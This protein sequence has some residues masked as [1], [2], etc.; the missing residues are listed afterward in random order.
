M[1]YTQLCLNWPLFYMYDQHVAF[2]EKK[3]A[4]IAG[5][6]RKRALESHR[7]VEIVYVL[8]YF[9]NTINAS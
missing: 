7:L 2:G 9:G 3:K 1:K 5:R 4:K 8:N 6:E